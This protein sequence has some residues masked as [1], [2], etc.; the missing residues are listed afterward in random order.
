[1]AKKPN[2]PADVQADDMQQDQ[3]EAVTV[4]LPAEGGP[5]PPAQGNEGQADTAGEG[6]PSSATS[7]PAVAPALIV[8]GPQSGRWRAGRKFGPAPETLLVSDLTDAEIDA[9]R[10][11]PALT[12][13]FIPAPN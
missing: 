7:E 9:L 1:M 2:K 12:I 5:T 4:G 8:T 3:T 11:D 13:V 10:A 6:Q